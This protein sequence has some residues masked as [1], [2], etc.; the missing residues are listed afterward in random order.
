VAEIRDD[1][2]LNEHGGILTKTADCFA[3]G[4]V[5]NSAT[6]GG[7]ICNASPAGDMIIP[8]ILL[9]AIVELASWADGAVAARTVPLCDL[10]VGPGETVIQANELLTSIR[11]PTPVS[12]PFARFSKFGLRPAM[13]IAVVSVGVFGQRRNGALEQVRVAFGAVAPI[14]LRGRR[15]ESAIEGRD[16]NDEVIAEAVQAAEEE[17]SPISD[18]R[19][20]AWYRRELVRTLLSRIL[21]DVSS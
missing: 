19:A 15:T 9:D 7:N 8:L 21:S 14:P 6:V 10:F 20:S 5:R 12:D 11:F 2:F 3:G 1:R 16:V 18:V 17:I 13:D 4:Q